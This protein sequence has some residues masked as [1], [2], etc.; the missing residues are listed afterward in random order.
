V[1]ARKDWWPSCGQFLPKQ[2]DRPSRA[3]VISE[4]VSE[5]IY[6]SPHS[7]RLVGRGRAGGFGVTSAPSN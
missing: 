5:L 7:I 2:G 4:E 3:L 6:V 1:R